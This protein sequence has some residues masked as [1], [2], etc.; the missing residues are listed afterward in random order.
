MKS[1]RLVHS[2]PD[3]A[4]RCAQRIVLGTALGVMIC[5][6]LTS[7]SQGAVPVSYARLDGLHIGMYTGQIQAMIGAPT[8]IVPDKGGSY[9]WLYGSRTFSRA[10]I[11]LSVGQDRR[12]KKLR[13]F[14]I[15]SRRPSAQIGGVKVG[16]PATKTGD[17]LPSFDCRP[18]SGDDVK[19]A[20]VTNWHTIETCGKRRGSRSVYIILHAN[21]VVGLNLYAL[22]FGG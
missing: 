12:T 22:G 6:H 1:L 2:I 18:L 9:L 17:R 20:D 19:A 4:A 10:R 16:D 15:T 13:L 5:G 3:R 7:V 11:A 8:K 14:D 21:R